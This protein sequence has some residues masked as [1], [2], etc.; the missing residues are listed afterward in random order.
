MSRE[1]IIEVRE[2]S[3]ALRNLVKGNEVSSAKHKGEMEVNGQIFNCILRNKNW[4]RFASLSAGVKEGIVV[5]FCE[6]PKTKYTKSGYVV[7]LLTLH[8][9]QLWIYISRNDLP[10]FYNA[11]L[12]G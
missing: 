3:F 1:T 8:S 6:Q 11:I 2:V 12:L 10:R 4:G 5:A 7:L 9:A